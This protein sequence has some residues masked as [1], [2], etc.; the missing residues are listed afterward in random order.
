MGDQLKTK[1]KKQQLSNNVFFDGF[2]ENV[3]SY[4]VKSKILLLPSLNEGMPN[5]VLEAAIYKIPAVVYDFKG[6]DEIILH[7]KTGF[8]AK[9]KKSFFQYAEKLLSNQRLRKIIGTNAQKRTFNNFGEDN[10]KKYL[11][12]LLN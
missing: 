6:A 9:N 12:L 5:C 4:L 8:I 3:N 7:R 1:I 10:L 11:K 2:K